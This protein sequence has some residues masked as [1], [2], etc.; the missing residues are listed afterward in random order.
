MHPPLDRPHPL[1]Q[2]VI[3][4]LKKCHADNP[5]RKFIG[6]CNEAKRALDE[7]FRKEKEEKRRQN[8]RRS[9]AGAAQ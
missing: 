8:L 6:A 2:K 9:V 3:Q 4:N 1:C 5:R 7:C